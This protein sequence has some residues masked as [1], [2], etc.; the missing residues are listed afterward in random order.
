MK[1]MDTL[2]SVYVQSLFSLQKREN[3]K[4][5]YH[6]TKKE[7]KKI[8]TL[9][10]LL[11]EWNDWNFFLLFLLYP[12]IEKKHENNGKA[13]EGSESFFFSISLL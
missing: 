9:H 11:I 7:R 10:K 6:E 1:L 5:V 13:L 8:K 3:G 4:K 2:F 12:E